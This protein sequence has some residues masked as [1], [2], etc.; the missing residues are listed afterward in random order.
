[1][2]ESTHSNLQDIDREVFCELEN[3]LKAKQPL[4]LTLSTKNPEELSSD[5]IERLFEKDIARG[6]TYERVAREN[7]IQLGDWTLDEEKNVISAPVHSPVFAGLQSLRDKEVSKPEMNASKV[8]EQ[9]HGP[10]RDNLRRIHTPLTRNEI[11]A[12]A[13]GQSDAVLSSTFWNSLRNVGTKLTPEDIAEN[14]FVDTVEAEFMADKKRQI[15]LF[16]QKVLIRLHLWIREYNKGNNRNANIQ[17]SSL[18]E[19]L[20][21]STQ[22]NTVPIGNTD[23]ERFPGLVAA[24]AVLLNAKFSQL[25]NWIKKREVGGEKLSP[26]HSIDE[27]INLT[28]ADFFQRKTI[29]TKM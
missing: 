17:S 27:F 5:E 11:Y 18:Q 1:M 10:N 13:A 25:Q 21:R 16:H 4:T 20:F 7:G 29:E 14:A 12:R 24:E 19:Y 9:S 6:E 26:I 28:E 22:N 8:E 2:T 23:G 15:Q 3:A